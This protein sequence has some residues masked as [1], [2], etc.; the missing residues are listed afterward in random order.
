MNLRSIVW[1]LAATAG[2]ALS[3]HAH[4]GHAPFSEGTKHFV[5][6]PAHLGAVLLFCGIVFAAAQ[7]LK[8]RPQRIAL[9][10]IAAL[11]AAVAI[12]F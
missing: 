11:I 10:S 4:P 8:G 12:L 2:A 3:A 1:S 6:S 9:R 7:L 5:T